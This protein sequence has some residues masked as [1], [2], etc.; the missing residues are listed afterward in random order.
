MCGG[1]AVAWAAAVT[2]LAAV[3]LFAPAARG[4]ISPGPLSRPH[5]NLEGNLNCLK[6]HGA[7]RG[8]VMDE[9]CIE[10]HKEIGWLAAQQRGFHGREGRQD[11]ARCHPEH[12]GVDFQLIRWD[13]GAPERFDHARTGWPLEGKHARLQCRECHARASF[14]I[15]PAAGL[16]PPRGGADFIGLEDA[17]GAC[18][19]DVHK[20]ALGADCRKCHTTEAWKPPLFDHQKTAF[21]L[22]GKHVGVPCAKCHMAPHLALP[23]DKAGHAQPLFKPVP[24]GECS[25]CHKDPHAGGLG[26]ACSRC[27]TVEDFR[28]VARNLFDHDRTRFPLRGRHATVACARCHTARA[29]GGAVDKPAFDRCGAC[30]R[31]AHAGLATLN[32]APADC[33]ACHTVDGWKPSSYTVAQ[34]ASSPYPLAGKHQQVGCDACHRKLGPEAPAAAEAGDARVLLRPRHAHCTDCHEDSHGGQLAHLP[35][36]GACE[37]C[38]RVEGFKPPTY[39]VQQHAAL[40][41]P[42]TGRHA[43]IACA[44]CHGPERPGLPP[45]ASEAVIGKA[46]VEFRLDDDCENCH[47]DPHRG[48]FSAT[49]K[50]RPAKACAA[51]HSTD[52]FRPSLVDDAAHRSFGMSLEGAHR[53]TPCSGCHRELQAPAATRTLLLTADGAR[54]L[55]FE[56]PRRRCEDCHESPHGDQ[57]ADRADHGACDGCHGVDSFKPAVRFDHNRDAA[58]PLRGAHVRVACDRCHPA[59]IAATGKQ[60]LIFKG[61]SKRCESCHGARPTA[62]PAGVRTESGPAGSRPGAP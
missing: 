9:R 4:Q 43:A 59:R 14:R 10:C 17:C 30:H 54:P 29:A 37:S 47:I 32:G 49:G 41:F 19:E 28:R 5:A 40:R 52:K 27:H 26:T 38:H 7:E 42:L 45:A 53:T 36:R 62:A 8:H 11:C 34:H 22:V 58:F 55:T 23:V 21:P 39:T 61:L 57:F 1:P 20:G 51:C 60:Q 2:T 24:H 25:A 15:S 50:G 56:D 12:G 18:H 44:A 35:D 3:V 46:R 33:S 6:C 48:R 13:E 16:G 31:D